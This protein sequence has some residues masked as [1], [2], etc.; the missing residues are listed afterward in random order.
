MKKIGIYPG[1]FQPA[2]RAHL[3]TYKR[4]KSVVGADCF[5][6]TTDREPTSDAP[7]NFGDKQQIWTRHGVP[8]NNIIRI[9]SLPTDEGGKSISWRPKEIFSNFSAKQTIAICVFN[10]MESLLFR[11]K[12]TTATI[13][14]MS[15]GTIKE[16]KTIFKELSGEK[17]SGETWVKPDGS[18]QYFQPYRSNEQSL[19]PFEEHTYVMILDDSKIQGK[20][21]STKNI[22]NVLGSTRYDENKK[23]KFFRWVFGW[24]DIGLYQLITTKLG[25]AHQVASPGDENLTQSDVV[26]L[27]TESLS[28]IPKGKL[29][30]IVYEILDE[31]MMDEDYS[32][33]INEPDSSTNMTNTNSQQTPAEK[34]TAANKQ[35]KDL[36]QKKKEIELQS[37][38]DKQQRDQYATTVRNFDSIKKKA[39]RDALDAVNKQISQPDQTSVVT[40]TTSTST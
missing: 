9:A 20:P 32:T 22:R 13:G 33:T 12:G 14:G 40:S 6:A 38:Q 27:T 4:L 10:E 15:A 21:T 28:N 16:I 34:V 35:K 8:S 2:T 5:I 36:V 24:F 19:R 7:L 39:N 3:E 17:P 1:S 23:K 31:I 26:G 29:E 11:R 30:K 37:K 25:K 18:A